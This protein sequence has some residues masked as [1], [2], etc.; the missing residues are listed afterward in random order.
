MLHNRLLHYLD[1]VAR[2]G[3]MR[4][5]SA[6]LNVASSAVNRQILALEAE[7][8]TP[9]FLR[10]PRKLMLT[11]A[12]EIVIRHVRQTL[13]EMERV[14]L[15]IEE[16]KGLRQGEITLALMS[17][18]A[19]N[20]VP[21]IA[22]DFRRKSPRVKLTLRLLTSGHEIMAAVS[23][24]EADLGLGFDFPRDPGLRVLAAGVG[25]LGAVLA[26]DHPL[27]ARQEV[28]LSDCA[29]YSLII[30]EE[31]MAIRPYLNEAFSAAALEVAPVLETNS[32]EVMRHAAMLDQA[33]TFLT[34]FDIEWER[35]AGRLAYVPVH[36]LQSRVQM[37]ML[38]GRDR[39]VDA[40]TSLM[41]E[42]IKAAIL[43]TSGG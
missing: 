39:S 3:S 10:L 17:G 37:L 22:V 41:A 21:R 33:I 2:T 16:L 5:A 4:R 38:I 29:D 20:M 14:Q 18:L 6:R 35:R 12:G 43:A 40:L 32:I 36:E 26:P 9:L 42:Q 34:P 31:G 8:G 25:R 13:K 28:R 19:A 23:A 15:R 30:A 7:L 27:A 24:G 11:A 1:E